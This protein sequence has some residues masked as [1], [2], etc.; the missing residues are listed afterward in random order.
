MAG[1]EGLTRA[2]LVGTVPLA[3]LEALGSKQAISVAFLMGNI[4]FMRLVKSRERAAMVGV[5]STWREVSFLVAPGLA[6]IVLVIGPFW[7]LYAVLAAVMLAGVRAA[8]YLPRR[9]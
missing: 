6:A 2:L 1:L 7:M 4:P 5:F 9:L 8:S 3:A